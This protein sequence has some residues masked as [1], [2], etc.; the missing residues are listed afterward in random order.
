M[1]IIFFPK[2]LKSIFLPLIA[3][4]YKDISG[5]TTYKVLQ[6]IGIAKNKKLTAILCGQFGDLGLPPKQSPFDIHAGLV[7]HYADG[8]IY[9]KGGPMEIVKSI[10]ST[11]NYHGGEVLTKARVEKILLDNNN[12][13]KGIQL[14]SGVVIDCQNVI[15]AIGNEQTSMLLDEQF[16]WKVKHPQGISHFYCFL[17]LKD[18][19]DLD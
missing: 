2:I 6:E 4:I 15:S 13:V 18:K 9:P 16:S 14:K 1:V 5:K 17:G 8:A 19:P 7:L 10:I 12:K 3:S 11:I